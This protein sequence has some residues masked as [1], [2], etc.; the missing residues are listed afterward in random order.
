M[1][2]ERGKEERRRRQFADPTVDMA[3]HMLEAMPNEG[4]NATMV[5]SQLS[6]A[7]ADLWCQGIK[8]AV[9]C[10]AGHKVACL[11]EVGVGTTNRSMEEA[12]LE[13]LSTSSRRSNASPAVSFPRLTVPCLPLPGLITPFSCHVFACSVASMLVHLIGLEI[14]SNPRFILNFKGNQ[15]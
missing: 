4:Q 11:G 2:L 8:I 1:S 15:L 12:G 5:F 9:N 14:G 13:V 3:F 10:N 7:W 6:V